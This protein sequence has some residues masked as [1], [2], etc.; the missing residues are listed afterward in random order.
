LSSLKKEFFGKLL[1]HSELIA[2]KGA[3]HALSTVEGD[4]KESV[5]EPPP[6]L[7]QSPIYK[8]STIR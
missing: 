3:K 4:A 2:R 8:L 1:A 5:R 6:V 7:D